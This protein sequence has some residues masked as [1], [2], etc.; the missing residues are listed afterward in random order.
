MA[1]AQVTK[2]QQLRYSSA[3][4]EMKKSMMMTTMIMKIMILQ[5]EAQFPSPFTIIIFA[6][7]FIA[8]QFAAR[9]DCLKVLKTADFPPPDFTDDGRAWA[10][11][12]R[13]RSLLSA[14]CTEKNSESF[15]LTSPQSTSQCN[16]NAGKLKRVWRFAAPHNCLP[17]FPFSSFHRRFHYKKKSQTLPPPLKNSKLKQSACV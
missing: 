5:T 15:S 7:H 2:G 11:T 3:E 8:L 9:R 6:T 14:H 1:V 16:V 17:F 12:K 4:P 13:F 10:H